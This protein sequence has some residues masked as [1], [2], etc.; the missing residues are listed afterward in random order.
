MTFVTGL[1]TAWRA[2]A[3]L[4]RRH[5]ANEAA[6]TCDACADELEATYRGVGSES[7]TLKQA[8]A[9]C[10]KSAGHLARLIREARIPNA[11]RK[12]APRILRRDL[13]GSGKHSVV[14]NRPQPYDPVTDARSLAS[15]LQPNGGEHGDQ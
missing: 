9:E 7:L 6:S 1:T 14:P 12:H 4:L 10:D 11:G 5:G 15:R 2:R 13:P 8:A 3:E